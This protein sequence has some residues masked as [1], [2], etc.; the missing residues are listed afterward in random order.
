MDQP[1]EKEVKSNGETDEHEHKL[2]IRLIG[3]LH[4][5][6]AESP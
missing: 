5:A 4:L 1:D 3:D 6:A 2:S